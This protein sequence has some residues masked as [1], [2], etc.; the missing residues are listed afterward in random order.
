MGGVSSLL[1]SACR[2]VGVA[3]ILLQLH[4]DQ[5]RM[6]ACCSRRLTIEGPFPFVEAMAEF[7]KGPYIKPKD[8]R[9]VKLDGLKLVRILNHETRGIYV[10][11]LC[12]VNSPT[13]GEFRTRLKA[14]PLL[15]LE[16]ATDMFRRH[17]RE[18]Y[19]H[20]KKTFQAVKVILSNQDKIEISSMI[21]LLLISSS[22]MG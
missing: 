13:D 10:S 7:K 8:P 9:R 20:M 17:V 11:F 22:D 12:D 2:K 21:D 3:A 18:L 19:I 6:V 15:T 1:S 16:G 4:E 14:G 5:W